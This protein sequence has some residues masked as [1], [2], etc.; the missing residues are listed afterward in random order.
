M[1]DNYNISV[2]GSINNSA[3]QQGSI[4]SNQSISQHTNFDYDKILAVLLEINK[5]TTSAKFFQ[6]FGSNAEETKILIDKAII[7][8]REKQ[9]P[10][11]ITPLMTKL[12]TLAA[13][14]SSGIIANLMYTMLGK[15]L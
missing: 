2:S 4:N 15:L 12:K 5:A 9:E 11:K 6:E 3:I 7:L 10:E 1:N 8:V 13:N 14:V